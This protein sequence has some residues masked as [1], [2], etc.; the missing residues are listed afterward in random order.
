MEPQMKAILTVSIY[1]ALVFALG[2]VMA[3]MTPRES[4]EQEIGDE[5]L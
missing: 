1:L 3:A 2:V 5:N 4:C